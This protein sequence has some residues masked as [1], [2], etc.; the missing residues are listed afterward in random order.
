MQGRCS[1]QLAGAVG[2]EVLDQVRMKV[3]GGRMK[4]AGKEQRARRKEQG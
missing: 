1:A 4:D 2:V 3:E